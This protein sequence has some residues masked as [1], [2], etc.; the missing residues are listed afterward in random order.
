MTLNQWMSSYIVETFSS[1]LNYILKALKHSH[2]IAAAGPPI[3]LWVIVMPS[4]NG[5]A[6]QRPGRVPDQW[7]LT[8]Q[9]S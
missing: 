8:I 4:G 2:D 7:R 5:P 1:N 3:G 6:A 9:A